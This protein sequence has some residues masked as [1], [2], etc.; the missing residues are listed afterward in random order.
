MYRADD[1]PVR[2]AIHINRLWSGVYKSCAR[3][4]QPTLLCIALECA[5]R[6]DACK[7]REPAANDRPSIGAPAASRPMQ[8]HVG[9]SQWRTTALRSERRPRAGRVVPSCA[10]TAA[11]THSS[12]AAMAFLSIPVAARKLTQPARDVFRWRPARG[13]AAE[14]IARTG[15]RGSCHRAYSGSVG[16]LNSAGSRMLPCPYCGKPA[17][18][19]SPGLRLDA[20][21]SG[22]NS[23]SEFRKSMIAL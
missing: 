5:L 11:R 2:F 23:T 19:R 9:V 16:S 17:V 14:A 12:T 20:V 6:I 10:A 3:I 1:G 13:R 22:G 15:L 21:S 7:I 18:L 8:D 4:Y